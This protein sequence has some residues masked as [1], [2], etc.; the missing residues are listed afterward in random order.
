MTAEQK[1]A[2]T[3]SHD[4]ARALV[5]AVAVGATLFPVA[6]IAQGLTREGFDMVKH[7]LSLLSTGDLGWI[8]ITNFVVSG[9][10]YIVG[11]YGISRVLRR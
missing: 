4:T 5:P 11:A 2:A 1:Y 6:G 10:L 8:N 9:V 3:S 7:P